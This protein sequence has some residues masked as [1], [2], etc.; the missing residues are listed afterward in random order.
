MSKL[1]AFAEL[2]R[3]ANVVTALSDIMAGLAIVG[4]TFGSL[5]Y[6]FYPA[7]F[8]GLSSMCLY[9]GG[10]VFNDIFDHE[11]DATERPE[12]ALPSGRIKRS[13]AVAGGILLLSAGIFLAFWQS[14]L[15]GIVAILITLLALFYDW[16]GKHMRIF[17]PINM[18]LCRAYNLL[19]GMSVY[20]LGVLEHFPVI[21]IPLIYIAAITLVSRGEVHGGK[22]T[23]LYFAGFLFLLV[24]AS[25]L[26]FAEKI[27]FA[28]V[29]VLAH[30]I[31]IFRK[32]R[33]AIVE[34]IGKNIGLTVKTGVLTL[35]LMNAAWIASSGQWIMALFVLA[36]LPVSLG[37]AKKFAVT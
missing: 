34:P 4:F 29:F 3:P 14:R 31:L 17:G 13:E 35:I 21:L 37:L 15:S 2:T 18:G 32:L 9:A 11:L 8:L 20:E 26:Y 30:F 28:L 25:Q 19:L 36:L 33:I 6:Q 23:T 27:E 10:V 12:R 24:H 5:D 1:R 16:K 7:L 22:A